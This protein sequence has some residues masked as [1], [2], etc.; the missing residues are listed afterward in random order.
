[1]RDAA[2]RRRARLDDRVV[3]PAGRVPD[4]VARLEPVGVGLDDLADGK[5]PVHRRLERERGEV[6]RRRRARGAAAG[7]PR[8]RT[9]TCCGRAP[10]P[11]PAPAPRPR[12]RGSRTAAPRRADTRP[13][14]PRGRSCA[15]E[16]EHLAPDP[17][18]VRARRGRRRR[19]ACRCR[20]ASMP[21]STISLQ[22]FGAVL[23]G[24]G[25]RETVDQLVRAG[26][27]RVEVDLARPPALD[28][29]DAAAGRRGTRPPSS[30]PPAGTRRGRTAAT[31]AA[32]FAS[33]PEKRACVTTRPRI[34]SR[35]LASRSSVTATCT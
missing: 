3:A 22:P 14:E 8:R 2:E 15:K 4:G 28:A 29:G 31:P 16:R 6:A 19:R 32:A 24:A 30:R 25:D 9:S 34:A 35:A 18:A 13:A 33:K 12:R 5:D 20:R 21:R 17:V 26:L 11:V 10:R 23:G 7:A 1:M 27:A